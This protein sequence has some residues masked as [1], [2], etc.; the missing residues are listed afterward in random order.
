VASAVLKIE[1]GPARSERANSLMLSLLGEQLAR[2]RLVRRGQPVYALNDPA[3]AVYYLKKGCVKLV[4]YSR[5]GEEV[6]L[7]RY[8]AGSLL[9]YLGFCKLSLDCEGIECES[10]VAVHNSEI[11]VATLQ[12]LKN[13]VLRYPQATLALLEDYC[14]RLAIARMRI[15]SLVLHEAEERLARMLLLLTNNDAL[16]SHCA[17][18]TAITH[19]ELAH[20]I[21]VT[22]PFVTRLM[23][24]LRVRGFIKPLA[25]G[26]ILVHREKISIAYSNSKLCA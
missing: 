12:A 24:R 3:D 25:A 18:N 15:E 21:G 6:I 7:D 26:R 5:L 1:V 4:R 17:S 13:N 23:N 19:E 20:W 22:R 11:I 9:G 16:G 10:A 2:V 8:E 14:R